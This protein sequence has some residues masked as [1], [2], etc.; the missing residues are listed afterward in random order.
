VHW[1]EPLPDEI[2]RAIVNWRK[3]MDTVGQFRC[4]RHYFGRGH[5]RRNRIARLRGCESISIRSSGLLE[6]HL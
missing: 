2:N 3:E 1:N 6:G 5:V 4:P